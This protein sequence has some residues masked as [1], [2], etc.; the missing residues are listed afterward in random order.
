MIIYL[1]GGING[2]LKVLWDQMKIY[3]AGINGRREAIFDEFIGKAMKIYLAGT[4]YGNQSR[5]IK[6]LGIKTPLPPILESFYYVD[7]TT[8]VMLP[9][10][11]DFLLDSGAFTYMT[12]NGGK[13]NWE[14]YIDDYAKFIV[15]NDIEKFIELDCVRVTADELDTYE[16]Y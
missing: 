6:S 3:L 9:F 12:G 10:M 8:E 1:A 7:E 16:A 14:K 5:A 13:V 15:K 2:N 11:K 4:Y